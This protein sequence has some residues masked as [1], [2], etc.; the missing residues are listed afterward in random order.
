MKLRKLKDQAQAFELRED[1]DRALQIYDRIL[2]AS[3]DPA[4][5]ALYNRAGDLHLRLGRPTRAVDY[6]LKA[7][8]RYGEDGLYNNAI[9]LCN[10]A[11]RHAPQRA[12][13]FLRLAE[14]CAQQGFAVEARRWAADYAELTLKGGGA[15]QAMKALDELA[16]RMDDPEIRVLLGWR[17]AK[18]GKKEEAVQQLVLAYEARA[19]ARRVREAESLR[20]E[21]LALDPESRL[22]PVAD[23]A[24]AAGES[25][26]GDAAFSNGPA[27]GGLA[28]VGD[29]DSD[30]GVPPL[31]LLDPEEPGSSLK[32]HRE[33]LKRLQHLAERRALRFFVIAADDALQTR[34]HVGVRGF[35]EK[36]AFEAR[37]QGHDWLPS[38]G[39]LLRAI[40]RYGGQILELTPE[41]RIAVF[42]AAGGHT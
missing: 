18:G 25:G 42:N 20:K 3:D 13:I 35:I 37:R 24:G 26:G 23:L 29:D 1:W 41:D 9:A 38:P 12:D 5:L 22:S 8:D 10:K 27:A 32:E 28:G 15:E 11:L 16:T 19:R 30:E 39:T 6:Y 14:Y 34:G 33:R 17:L 7:A 40:D 31:P 36:H 2:E 4:D 21:I